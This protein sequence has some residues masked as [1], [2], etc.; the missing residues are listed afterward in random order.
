MNMYARIKQIFA[1]TP[2]NKR[3][4]YQ[5]GD[6]SLRNIPSKSREYGAPKSRRS[7]LR[8][9][10]KRNAPAEKNVYSSRD[11]TKSYKNLIRPVVFASVVM[12]FV[13]FGGT[14]RIEKRLHRIEYFKV[15]EISI[16]GE[17]VLSRE[18]LR[19]T[20]GVIA[21]QTSL[22]GLDTKEVEKKLLAN[23][24]VA[25]AKVRRSWPS[26]IVIEVV[27]NIPLAILHQKTKEGTEFF[28]IDK[29]GR[30][31]LSVK[32]GSKVDFPV[33]TGLSDIEKQE[34]H[35]AAL[36]EV[37]I[38]LNKA[39]RNDPHLP[40]QSLSEIHVTK[41]GELVVYLVEYPF[42][43]FFGNGNTKR[44][45]GRLVEVL[46]ALYKKEKGKDL[47]SEVKYIQMDYLQDK[48]L[49]AQSGQG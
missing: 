10:I 36:K 4:K 3:S 2:G 49:V 47:I 8:R 16:S 20:A 35:D 48:V 7:N 32:P 37:L 42:P 26:R 17:S 29:R 27:E 46:K 44:K 39:R 45:Y 30:S 6:I 24:W 25:Q 18:E 41:E 9:F 12:V 13:I 40:V 5:A 33:I 28:Y 14:E 34:T 21:H 23:S 38:F 22:I 31:F 19:S 43:I 15:A 11:E 1:A